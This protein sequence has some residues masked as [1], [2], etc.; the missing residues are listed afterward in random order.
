MFSNTELKARP[1]SQLRKNDM[2]LHVLWRGWCGVV[3]WSE[4]SKH[5]R[6]MTSD[7]VF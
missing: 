4:M 6:S 3:P 7:P 2:H 5:I 1:E